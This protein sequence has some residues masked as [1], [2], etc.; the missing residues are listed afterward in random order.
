MG[1]GGVRG[2][3]LG[4]RGGDEVTETEEQKRLRLVLSVA[5]AEAA[6]RQAWWSLLGVAVSGVGVFVA[7]TGPGV[8]ESV[9]GMLIS[10]AGLGF[11]GWC[12]MQTQRLVQRSKRLMRGPGR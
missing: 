12:A 6:V 3:D 2:V 1:L 5:F 9:G 4:C 8:V 11:V 10:F 7:F